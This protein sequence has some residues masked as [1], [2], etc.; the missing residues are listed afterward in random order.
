MSSRLARE[1]TAL[2][3]EVSGFRLAD[4]LQA[5]APYVQPGPLTARGLQC[6]QANALALARRALPE[7]FP[8]LAQ[9]LGADSF[10][11]LAADFW[12]RH[13]PVRGDIAQWG[14]DL[15]AFV[16]A[17]PQLADTPYLADVAR[18]EWALHTVATAD[19]HGVDMASFALLTEADPATFTLQ[20]AQP[21]HSVASPWPVVT[22]V[23]AHRQGAAAL[24]ALP[25]RLADLS[26]RDARA[27]TALVWRHG[28]R[29][30][31]RQAAPGE[32]AFVVA[33]QHGASLIDALET[34]SHA[35]GFDFNAWLP[36]AVRTARVTG[37]RP[38]HPHP[39]VA[40]DP[41]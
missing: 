8:V 40:G 26:A 15:P 36:D 24:A 5:M 32:M 37:A 35:D 21:L 1:Q 7:A 20:C 23:D 34:A 16:A 39:A 25:E 2:L 30:M 29:P 12:Q 27:E 4:A 28:L 13:P 11:D 31:L 38:L 18:V 10:A 33:L 3:A 19:D 22:L 14:A 17:S 9:M 6:Y 41:P